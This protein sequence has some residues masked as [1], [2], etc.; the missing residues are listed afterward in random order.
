MTPKE[1]TTHSLGTSAIDYLKLS[2][3][4]FRKT[5]KLKEKYNLRK[6]LINCIIT[7]LARKKE[8]LE[9]QYVK[10]KLYRIEVNLHDTI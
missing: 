4:G 6:A 5:M 8:C 3:T 1:V 2:M 10:L 7:L 9:P